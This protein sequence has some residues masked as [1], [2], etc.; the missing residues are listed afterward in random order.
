MTFRINLKSI[1]LF[2]AGFLLFFGMAKSQTV[3]QGNG[4]VNQC[5][6]NFYDSGNVGGNYANNENSTRTICSNA[7]NCVRV[8]FTSFNTENCCDFLRIYDGPSAA[9]P[10]IG[11]YNGATS[12]GVVT[13]STGCLTFVFTSD[14]SITSSGWAATIS[15][16]ACG[17]PPPC[18]PNMSNCTANTCSGNFYDSGGIGGNH[19]NN[20]NFTTT[21]CSDAGNC[22]A[23]NFTA[24]QLESCC[25]FL[26]IY[27]GP[28][29]GAPLI[30][31]F[32]GAVSPGLVTSTTG[33]LTF[34]F[35]SDGSVVN[36]GW[37]ASISCG[38][39]GGVG[40]CLPNM[41]DCLDNACAG[42]FYDSGG[43]GGNYGNNETLLHTICSSAGNCVTL[44]FTSFN[45]ENGFD[46]LR[47]YDGPN[48]GMPLIG[49]YTGTTLPGSVS[50]TLTGC[51]TFE[52]TSD[53]S[54]TAP[55]WEAA[56]SCAACA[57]PFNCLIDPI[58]GGHGSP[59]GFTQACDDACS[60]NLINLGF[61]YDIC[62][63]NYTS[64]YVNM[65]G[66]VT[67]GSSYTTFTPVGMPNNSTAV[68]VAPFWADVDTRSCGT[69]YYRSNPTNCIVTW[70]NVGY[71][72]SQ[73]D[74]LNTFQAVLS[75]GS[76]P[77]IGIGNNTAF[78]FGD[79]N[80]TTGSAS[81]GVNGFG[82]SPATVGINANDGV[83]YSAIGR[84]D[85]AGVDYDG[86]D[87][88]TDGVD[89]LDFRCFTFPA[90]GCVI[91]PVN[92]V[93]IEAKIIDNSYVL[94][95]W[96]T[97]AESNNYGF[98]VERSIDNVNYNSIAF[99]EGQ[100]DRGDTILSYGHP[101]YSV[102]PNIDYYYRLK[103]LDKNGL[104]SY[105]PV[106]HALVMDENAISLGAFYPNPFEDGLAVDLN[107]PNWGEVNIQIFNHV[108]Q[109]VS[110]D[111]YQAKPGAQVLKV[112]TRKLARGVY[113]V[114]VRLDNRMIS[115]QKVLK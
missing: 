99:V 51:L 56:I 38:P 21:I 89:W 87:L 73:C 71:Y 83:L 9:S 93:K 32:T 5:S 44:N 95:D 36:F 58:A 113:M 25:D 65:N 84:F 7:G 3:L 42:N 67:F 102:E 52:F 105:S 49:T 78:Y 75:D 61:T 34:V 76:D 64:F 2:L 107:S 26:R 98:E 72:N 15:C 62:G 45:L 29:A 59:A 115:V 101:D 86:P 16:V 17:A 14:G 112:D 41:G 10:L 35:T 33:C 74:K 37:E 31:T 63:V 12:P 47:I 81:G 23:V 92:F 108:G 110:S 82:G 94:I 109:I 54:N 18:L 106:V 97:N 104:F 69:V 57:A 8:T 1:F 85:H 28:N 13:S 24:F 46:F 66:N 55:G 50:S 43:L 48:T 88:T 39:C 22:V 70:Y 20:E 111:A 100:G 11:T 77:L 103:Q 4:T 6:G 80:W 60:S 30:G 40:P 68:M 53:G 114:E 27:D 79:M 96:S 19:A 91:L 90:G